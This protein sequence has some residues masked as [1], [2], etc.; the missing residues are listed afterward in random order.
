[1]GRVN[2]MQVHRIYRLQ[3]STRALD[4]HVSRL[5]QRI[6]VER[7]NAKRIY[8]EFYQHID[9]NEAFIMMIKTL[10]NTATVRVSH[11]AIM[12]LIDDLAYQA[13]FNEDDTSLRKACQHAVRSLRK[14]M[15]RDHGV[16]VVPR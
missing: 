13:E 9:N 3:V 8:T 10:K 6:V 1:V 14:Q 15:A 16:V 12:E 4:D 5:Y 11:A 2:D 7:E